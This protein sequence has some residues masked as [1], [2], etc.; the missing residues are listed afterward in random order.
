MNVSIVILAAGL[1]TRMKSSKAKVL[2]K[3]CNKSIIWHI[4][5]Q[6]YKISNE[7]NVVLA[8]QK[9][10]IEEEIKKYFPQT[11]IILQDINNF[12]GTAGALKNFKT[13]KEKTLILCGDMPLIKEESLKKL[14]NLKN[15]FNIAIFDAKKSNNYGKV[16]IE[17]NKITKII[18]AKDASEKEKNITLCNSGVYAI[19]SSLLFK[20]LP[21]IKNNNNVKEYYLTDIVKLA[22]DLKEQILPILVDENEFMG[23]ND[24]FELSQAQNLMQYEIKKELM[25]KGIVF[26]NPN[27]SF[28]DPD[29]L[30]EGECEIYENVRIEG[31]SIIKNSIIKSSSIIEDSNIINSSI[32]PLSHIR[33]K[34][35]IIDSNIGNFVECKNAKLF[36]IKAGHLSYLGDC[37]ID[38]GTN[39]GCGCITC[40]YDGIKKSYTKIGKNVFVGSDTQ[41]IAPVCIEDDVIIAAGSCVDQNL[42]KG[43]LFI[44]RAQKKI[45]KNYFYKKIGK[46]I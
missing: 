4:L 29:V 18:E 43:V 44:N 36:S 31:K 35:E 14:L 15:N 1:G 10:I 34:C 22:N 21:Q 33:P 5:K 13:D 11:K 26:H 2:H 42:N 7:V 16:I 12:P 40:N 3:I 28:I 46:K 25:Q 8:Y 30:F 17:D 45:I 6:A 27:S 32:G 9:E 38:E 41:F 39:I 20:I 23:V 24:K 19:N 37:H